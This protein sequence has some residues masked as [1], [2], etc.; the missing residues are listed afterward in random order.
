MKENNLPQTV[1]LSFILINRVTLSASLT[2]LSSATFDLEKINYTKDHIIQSSHKLLPGNRSYGFGNYAI[3]PAF[4][5]SFSYSMLQHLPY[6]YSC[7]FTCL[8][9]GSGPQNRGYIIFFLVFYHCSLVLTGQE[10]GSE[11]NENNHYSLCSYCL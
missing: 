6:Y 8:P 10:K 3:K 1:S 4:L 5:W 9:V 11:R 7:W 2:L